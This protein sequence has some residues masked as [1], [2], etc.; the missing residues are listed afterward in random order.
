ML[1]NVL[2][3]GRR[4]QLGAHRSSFRAWSKR[5]TLPEMRLTLLVAFPLAAGC[6]MSD[7]DRIGPDSS[8]PSDGSGPEMAGR[9]ALSNERGGASTAGVAFASFGPENQSCTSVHTIGSCVVSMYCGG[10]MSSFYSAGVVDISGSS[11][12]FSMNPDGNGYYAPYRT[13]AEIYPS[14]SSVEVVL[15]G[16]IVPP[17][18]VEAIAPS[19][20]EVRT[21]QSALASID[22]SQD[23]ALSWTG[24]SDGFLDV[25]F[26]DDLGVDVV[27]SFDCRYQAG[28]GSATVPAEVLQTLRNRTGTL[29]VTTLTESVSDVGAWTVAFRLVYNAVWSNGDS[30]DASVQIY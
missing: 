1:H 25:V 4:S 18:H 13:S 22:S 19:Q 7:T 9:I 16:D 27:S 23:L 5:S 26:H 6:H 28:A 3:A 21:D 12:P 17:G 20:V 14:G 8:L 30:A 10:S 15:H 29:S 2:K 11:E 24:M